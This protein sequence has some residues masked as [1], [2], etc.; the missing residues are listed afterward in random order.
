MATYKTE[1]GKE[2]KFIAARKGEVSKSE[3]ARQLMIELNGQKTYKEMVDAIQ[4]KTQ[5]SR[6]ISARYLKVNAKRIDDFKTA[7]GKI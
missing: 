6:M 5:L 1:K 7:D 4:A 2:R 3:Q